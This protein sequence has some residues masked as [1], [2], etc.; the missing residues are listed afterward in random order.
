MYL[1][2]RNCRLTCNVF[3]YANVYIQNMW[4]RQLLLYRNVAITA[5]TIGIFPSSLNNDKNMVLFYANNW[6]EHVNDVQ[7]V[8]DV[9]ND[10]DNDEN[11][12]NGW[13]WEWFRQTRT[14]QHKSRTY[15][16]TLTTPPP[17]HT[18]SIIFTFM[19]K[20][21]LLLKMFIMQLMLEN[22]TNNFTK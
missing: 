9:D 7:N 16:N 20:T 17:I 10:A 13:T 4:C 5:I 6:C 2:L 18:S 22:F 11:F 15:Q 8:D 21:Q 1:I 3:T 19:S 14:H 12:H